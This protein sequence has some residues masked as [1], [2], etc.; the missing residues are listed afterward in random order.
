MNLLVFDNVTATNKT[1]KTWVTYIID[2][3]GRSIQNIWST[4]S[5][6]L[7]GLCIPFEFTY[8]SNAPIRVNE[9][10]MFPEVYLYHALYSFKLRRA[11]NYHMPVNITNIRKL[12]LSHINGKYEQFKSMNSLFNLNDMYIVNNVWQNIF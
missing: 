7:K 12:E 3:N 6:F 1:T 2:S 10:N 11:F 5:C 8:I 4:S 9:R